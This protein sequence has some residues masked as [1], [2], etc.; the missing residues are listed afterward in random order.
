MAAKYTADQKAAARAAGQRLATI[1]VGSAEWSQ[2]V[3]AA[4]E[5]EL[6]RFYLDFVERYEAKRSAADAKPEGA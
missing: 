6:M 1:A 3:D 5:R 2:P 4:E